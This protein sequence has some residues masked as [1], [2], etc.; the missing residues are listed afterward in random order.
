MTRLST[1]YVLMA[2][3]N[4]GPWGD[5]IWRVGYTAQLVEGG[6]GGPYWLVSPP[7]GE[8]NSS[9]P[10]TTFIIGGL[11]TERVSQS[12]FLLVAILSLAIEPAAD[13]IKIPASI[14]IQNGAVNRWERPSES[15]LEVL[16]RRAE[17]L[18]VGLVSLDSQAIFNDEAV[19]KFREF[20]IE[21]HVFNEERKS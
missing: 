4:V 11:D 14:E 15:E 20:G 1:L 19:G 21:T 13:D 17:R 5:S 9:V 10:V 2:P 7:S 12:L 18:K 16:S 8:E 3:R 6:S